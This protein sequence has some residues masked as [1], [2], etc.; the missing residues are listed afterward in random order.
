NHFFNGDLTSALNCD[1]LSRAIRWPRSRRRL[2]SINFSP[3]C[4]P[5]AWSTVSRP[6]T[7]TVVCVDGPPRTMAPARRAARIA[8]LRA[9]AR[10]RENGGERLMRAFARGQRARAQSRRCSVEPLD[11]LVRALVPLPPLAEA[12]M[13]DRLQMIAGREAAL[14]L[15]A[16]ARA[17]V[18]LQQHA[19]Q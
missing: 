4:L 7:T 14:I 9:G 18:A 11:E 3:P 10:M 16:E 12:S 13:H 2:L 6:R 19:H 8:S 1:P 17:R 15:R 5:A